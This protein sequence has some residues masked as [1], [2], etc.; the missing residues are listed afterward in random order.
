[1]CAP[2]AHLMSRVSAI[3]IE[4]VHAAH[5]SHQIGYIVLMAGNEK[6]CMPCT[7]I[8]I[9][10]WNVSQQIAPID[11][12]IRHGLPLQCIACFNWNYQFGFI[13]SP[14][15]QPSDPKH[16]VCVTSSIRRNPAI[17]PCSKC[18]VKLL[19]FMYKASVIAFQDFHWQQP[20]V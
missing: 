14:F 17:L 3:Y 13:A 16:P 15:T 18:S 8:S 4:H 7:V 12:D 9:S 5:A 2:H 11:A 10:N 1:M 19:V 6:Q 20:A